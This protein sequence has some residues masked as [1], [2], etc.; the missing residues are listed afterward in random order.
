MGYYETYFLLL[1]LIRPIRSASVF[2][3]CNA[4][5]FVTAGTAL[6]LSNHGVIRLNG[7][8]IYVPVSLLLI[9][10][11]VDWL[12]HVPG[13]RIRTGGAVAPDRSPAT[14]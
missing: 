6:M 8:A 13:L 10:V 14:G 7:A 5:M 12:L 1:G 11:S 9:V 2:L 4:L 3:I